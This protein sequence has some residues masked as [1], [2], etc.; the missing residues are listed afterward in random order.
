MAVNNQPHT[1]LVTPNLVQIMVG[2]ADNFIT[3]I[4]IGRQFNNVRFSPNIFTPYPGIPIW[5]QLREL[6]V[7]EPRTLQPDVEQNE[8][9]TARLDRRQR[10]VGIARQPRAMALVGQ[11]ARNE[12]ANVV[13]VVDDQ[14]IGRHQFINA[15]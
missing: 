14:D 12:L 7:V 9:R 6:G 3:N 11:D 1:V 15:R 13:F 10:F 8:L 2:V 4:H 5:P